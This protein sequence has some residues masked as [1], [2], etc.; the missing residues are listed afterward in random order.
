MIVRWCWC[1]IRRKT[2]GSQIIQNHGRLGKQF[3]ACYNGSKGIPRS[4]TQKKPRKMGNTPKDIDDFSAEDV[5]S[6]INR[7][8]TVKFPNPYGSKATIQ[9]GGQMRI[10]GW[11]D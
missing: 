7:L 6:V 8:D 9:R 10:Y 2:H 1:P 11:S 4:L 3:E 5:W